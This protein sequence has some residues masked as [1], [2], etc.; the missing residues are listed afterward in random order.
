MLRGK[1]IIL[2]VCGSIA[3]YK[4]AF[5]VRL[6]V[7]EGA[8]VKV[9]MTPSA[10]DFITPM[11]LATLSKNP[12][13][14]SFSKGGSPKTGTGEWNNHVELGLWADLMII[15]P[16]SASTI[17][18]MANGIC[19]NLLIATYLSAR[20]PVM[21][22]PAMDLDMYSH[23]STTQN[24]EKLRSYGNHVIDAEHGELAS[25]LSGA[26]RMAE[27]DNILQAL[28][29]FF[30]DNQ[31]LSKKKVLITAGP[32]YEAIDP[33]RFIGNHSSG[34]MGYAIAESIASRGADV[35]LVSG[36]TSM[37]TRNKGISLSPVVSAQ[38]M[39]DEC[40][41]Q[42]PDCDVAILA[43]AVADYKPTHPADQKI[44][45]KDDSMSLDLEKTHDIAA[46]LGKIKTKDQ[47]VVGFALETENESGNAMEKLKSKNFD[48]IVLNSLQDAGA[49]FGHDTN[50]VTIIDR[51]NN[52]KEFQL[53][54]KSEVAED[55]VNEILDHI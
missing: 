54:N 21:L 4:T 23:P 42:F 52:S 32:T 25:G 41:T 9:I 34:K 28:Q 10:S 13:L 22:A 45:K 16:I 12:V 5:L 33:V 36:P 20:C 51:D 29:D 37:T 6:L 3:A 8:E 40:M 2:G 19:D 30:S 55:I 14:S 35:R 46:S 31:A 27:P 38:E 47:F 44:K 50:K 48:M 49:G 53:K 7:K 26:G 24:I 39:Y 15:A 43:A 17:G 1:K 18:K 11:T